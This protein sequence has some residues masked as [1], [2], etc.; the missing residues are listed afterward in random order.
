MLQ[1]D[2]FPPSVSVRIL[3][4]LI[5]GQRSAGQGGASWVTPWGHLLPPL[6]VRGTY[7]FLLQG[8]APPLSQPRLF[9]F[10]M[11]RH[12]NDAVHSQLRGS[13]TAALLVPSSVP[14]DSLGI[15][16]IPKIPEK[17]KYEIFNPFNY[18]APEPHTQKHPTLQRAVLANRTI[19]SY[20][21]A[22]IPALSMRGTEPCTTQHPQ[23]R[24]EFWDPHLLPD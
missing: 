5:D 24:G 15:M 20:P 16:Q 22:Q 13:F 7:K 1:D 4:V 19:S 21:W 8:S 18:S 2:R 11:C 23:Q 9:S 12:R 14:A 3:T 6:T 10:P 17:P